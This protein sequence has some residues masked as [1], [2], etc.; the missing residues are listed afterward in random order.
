MS[1]SNSFVATKNTLGEVV[2]KWYHDSQ[3]IETYI[4]IA[5]FNGV[6]SV[7][8]GVSFEPSRTNYE[9][10]D[11]ILNAYVGEKVYTLAF[12]NYDGTT[13]LS[14]IMITYNKDTNI[15]LDYLI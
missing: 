2:L 9:F 15:P 4:V 5:K 3:D 12:I 6:T 14:D 11:R 10:V 8:G 7:L 13:S 1:L